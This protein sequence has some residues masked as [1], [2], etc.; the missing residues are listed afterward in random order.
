MWETA[1]RTRAFQAAIAGAP[2]YRHGMLRLWGIPE[3]E[4]ASTLRAA[5]EAGI[6]LEHLE[7]TTCVRRGE[8]E[9]STRYEP[10]AEP[11][12]QA[13]VE[14]IRQRHRESLFSDDGSTVDQQV[15]GLLDGQMVAV[16]ES[17]TG[18]LMSA[19]LTERGG[20]SAYFAGGIVAYSNEAKR[21]VVGVDTELI[22]RVGA[23]SEEVAEALAEGA[24]SRFG[25]A[26][27]IGITGIAGPDGGTD[28][29][30][31]GTV[32][33]SIASASGEQITRTVRLPG[34]RADVRDR[35]TTVAMHLLRRLLVR[36]A[37]ADSYAARLPDADVTGT[38]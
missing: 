36:V 19:R 38:R 15:T 13:L 11:D 30:P 12:Y 18:G 32:C 31:V 4:I 35:S 8:I 6:T 33:F 26:F 16:A 23:V 29:K 5:E 22:G 34:S 3:S 7:V 2:E 25:A 24:I 9:V 10:S 37:S 17:C 21:D 27:G 1:R 28:E 20:S 14:F